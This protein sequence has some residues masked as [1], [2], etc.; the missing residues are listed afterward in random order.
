MP[1]KREYWRKLDNAAN[2]Y[3]A[4]SNDKITRVFRFYCELNEEI[5]C[6]TLQE[7]LN[8]TLH[9]YPIFLSVI[10]K[11]LFWHYLEKSSLRPVV[12]EENKKP[13]STIY[14]QD[15]KS[16]LFE[17]TYYKN[18]I[19]F[20]VFHVLT[21]GTGAIAF[22]KELVKNYLC[23]RHE[24]ENK[25]LCDPS[26]TIQDQESNAFN[27]YYK[28][29][30]AEAE[31]KQ[32]AYQIKKSY[33][34]TDGLFIHEASIPVKQLLACAKRY[35]VSL[36]EYLCAVMMVAIQKEMSQ[37]EKEKR[38]V[39][40]MV[41]VN[42][43]NFFA[44]QSMLN[45]FS[46][47]TPSFTFDHEAN[48]EEILQSIHAYFQEAL[49]VERIA[50][51][52]N[53]MIHLEKHPILRLIPLEVKNL[54]IKAG[55]RF[56]ERDVTAI[57]SNM[58]VVKLPDVYMPYIQRFGIFT[59]TPK[60]ELTLCSF[61]DQITLSFTSTFDT[62]NIQRNF[63]KLLA[64][65]QVQA[66][67]IEPAFPEVEMDHVHT[68][69]KLYS[70][71]CLALIATCTAIHFTFDVSTGWTLVMSCGIA[72]AWAIVYVGYKKRYNVLKN[73]MWQLILLS[74]GSL[75]WDACIG[76]KGWSVN[77]FIPVLCMFV[78]LFIFVIAIVRKDTAR[79]YMIYLVMN[80][81]YGM[82]VPLIFM[83]CGWIQWRLLSVLCILISFLCFVAI[84]MFKNNEFKE[85]MNKKFHW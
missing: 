8:R 18:R 54:G 49:Q 83:L 38:P 35:Q 40:L 31:K 42:L 50:E 68:W 4:T 71:L 25:T 41:P 5:D 69:F 32:K 55:S 66:Q 65:H 1:Q 76:W 77:Y 2:M 46:Y 34:K 84:L 60:L 57:L 27:Q 62:L 33:K 82:L 29:E 80:C 64:Q 58:G 79:E 78:L 63:Y 16:L 15:K 75:L 52:M 3:S 28:K 12:H 21:D 19:N 85:E 39:T 11:G 30:K 59:N 36:T 61:H 10:R 51:H 81:M 13:C 74:I 37:M 45:F 14:I 26:I 9:T 56:A 53:R 7:A 73:A 17:V 47:I 6:D 24:L 72:S 70:F 67:E 43:R 22:L 20:E 23:I 48:F 44:S